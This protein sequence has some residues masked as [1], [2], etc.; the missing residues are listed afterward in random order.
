[1]KVPPGDKT[2]GFEIRDGDRWVFTNTIFEVLR[3]NG[4][5][6]TYLQTL[7]PALYKTLPAVDEVLLSFVSTLRKPLPA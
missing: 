4:N 1:M 6:I 2:L 7:L 3:G 5:V